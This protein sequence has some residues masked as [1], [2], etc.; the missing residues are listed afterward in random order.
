MVTH[1]QFETRVK[2]EEA[3][4]V[5]SILRTVTEKLG[6]LGKTAECNIGTGGSN[7]IPSPLFHSN[8]S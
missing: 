2:S 1:L 8:L 5:K 3:M 7:G 4:E 6:S